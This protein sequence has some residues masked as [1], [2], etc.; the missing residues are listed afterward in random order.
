MDYKIHNGSLYDYTAGVACG[1]LVKEKIMRKLV[2]IQNR[3]LEE[4]KRVLSDGADSGSVFP[5]MW[6]LHYPQGIQTHV[7]YIDSAADVKNNIEWAIK[8]D[9]PTHRPLV[10]IAKNMKDAERMADAR[11]EE[12]GK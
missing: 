2:K 8:A 4:I 7:Y 5:S 12:V 11:Y 3:Y 10:F 1:V 9:T 6:T